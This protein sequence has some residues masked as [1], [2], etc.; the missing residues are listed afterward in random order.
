MAKVVDLERRKVDKLA[1]Q[2]EQQLAVLPPM[3]HLH[4]PISEVEDPQRWRRAARLAAHRLGWR[5]ATGVSRHGF[6]WLTDIREP[7]PEVLKAHTAEVMDRLDRMIAEARAARHRP[8]AR[9]HQGRRL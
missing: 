5:V 9:P 8:P 1:D 7:P 3:S 2:I 4:V 6:V